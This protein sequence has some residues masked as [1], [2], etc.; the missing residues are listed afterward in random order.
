LG[1]SSFVNGTILCFEQKK[2]PQLLAK[3]PYL[4]TMNGE[5]VPLGELASA[6]LT[7][8]SPSDIQAFHSRVYSEALVRGAE[9]SAKVGIDVVVLCVHCR[10]SFCAVVE[11]DYR[12]VV[13]RTTHLYGIPPP[14]WFWICPSLA[15]R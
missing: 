14:F 6:V 3:L 10:A 15:C 12:H 7:N 5:S 2:R 4:A 8:G 13:R 11:P 9:L 1:G